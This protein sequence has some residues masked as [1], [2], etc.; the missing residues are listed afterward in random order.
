M[1]K[2]DLI[3]AIAADAGITKAAAKLAFRKR[4]RYFEKR[5]KSISCW[6]WILVSI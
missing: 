6:I 1:N 4:R 3:D 5:R 2:S